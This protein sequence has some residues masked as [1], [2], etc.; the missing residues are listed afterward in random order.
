MTK[1]VVLDSLFASL[2]V[3][4]QA[5][6][7]AGAS[8]ERWNGD[9]GS[10]ADAEVVAHVRTRVDAGLLAAMPRCRVVSRFGSG[11]DTV[12]L[13]AAEA[14]GVEVVTVRDYCVPELTTHTLALAFALVRRL[15]ET[16]GRLDASWDVVAAE[17]PL[18]RHGTATVVGMGSIG[19]S[20][21]SALVALRYDVL[22]VTRRAQ[23]AA[24]RLAARVVDLN[25]GLAAADIVFLHA[26]LDETTR[27]LVD[28]PRIAAM[29]P[30]AILVNT[31]R[32]GLM[33]SAAVATALDERRLGGLA[34]DGLLPTDSPLR[35]L[36]GDPRVLVTPHVGWYSEES[37]TTL[38]R[39]AIAKALAA[40]AA[41]PEAG[42]VRS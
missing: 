27:E 36:A 11:I 20:V 22:A 41:L 25:E 24:H 5:A 23:E 12:D 39:E 37:A 31:A 15:G 13:A 2:D 29:R 40:L 9:P 32:L 35:R 28:A 4:E 10:L 26:A 19:R 18:R 21:A 33:D 17:T 1:V 14:A 42:A 7:E 6:R 30:G 38:R 34:L 8:L 16:A 3:E